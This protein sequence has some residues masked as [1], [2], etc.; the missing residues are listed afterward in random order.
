MVRRKDYAN[1]ERLTPP[2]WTLL[3]DHSIDL[4]VLAGFLSVLGAKVIAAYPAES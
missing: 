1:S 3:K 2:C 4:V